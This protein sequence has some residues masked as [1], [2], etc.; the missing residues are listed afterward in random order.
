MSMYIFSV[1]TNGKRLNLEYRIVEQKH[2]LRFK[3]CKQNKN[4]IIEPIKLVNLLNKYNLAIND[5]NILKMPN[6]VIAYQ[7][8]KELEYILKEG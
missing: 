4:N 5:N 1:V 7:F 3:F 8:Q 2:D 6:G